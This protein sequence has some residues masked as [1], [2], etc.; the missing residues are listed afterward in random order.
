LLYLTTRDNANAYTA[1]KTLC[2]DA[3]PDGGLFVPYKLPYIEQLQ[4]DSI[5]RGT[6]GDA[7]AQILNLFF[8]VRLNGWDIDL[9]IGRN[10]ARII[11]MNRKI[12]I[13]ELWNNPGAG[14]EHLIKGLYNCIATNTEHSNIP[15]LWARTVI[16]MAILFGLY[17]QIRQEGC[18]DP[19]IDISV[20]MQ[21]VTELLSAWYAR[22]IGLPIG[23]II[24]CCD[25]GDAFWDLLHGG[26]LNT[27][28][29]GSSQLT[30]SELL[31]CETL[32]NLQAQYFVSV[33]NRRGTFTI[34]EEEHQLLSAGIYP[35]A[36]GPDRVDSVISSIRRSAGYSADASAAVTYG[37][38]Q[39][40]RAQTG[41]SCLTLL[42]SQC[43]P[44][45]A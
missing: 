1:H 3:A 7:V 29:I 35:V 24:C 2:A 36:I 44:N 10:P 41:E 5:A 19:L 23:K 13:A 27:K 30:A 31:V 43:A 33:A 28:N 25:S 38:L 6:F 16:R 9:Q 45:N 8:A 34:S 32:G 20:N 26:T 21:D 39:D 22:A 4:L 18:A 15:T 14:I 11:L 42:L 37:G 12:V 17:T 40:Y